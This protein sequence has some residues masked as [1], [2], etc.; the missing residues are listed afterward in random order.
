M[1]A[2]LAHVVQQRQALAANRTESRPDDP[3]ERDHPLGPQ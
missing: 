1:A 2:E 3:A